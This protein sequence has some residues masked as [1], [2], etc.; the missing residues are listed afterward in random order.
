M[1][2]Y[3]V[4]VI[5]SGIGGLT[6]ALSCARAGRSV[7][8]LEAGKQYGGYSNPF[9]R[10]HFHFDP[11]IHY[12]GECG[13]DG[14]F[15]QLLDKLGLESV[16]FVELDRDAIDHYVF[17]DYDRLPARAREPRAV[18]PLPRRLRYHAQVRARHPLRAGHVACRTRP[19]EHLALEPR[20]GDPMPR[21]LLRGSAAQGCA[22]RAMR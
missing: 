1:T 19:A 15:R 17:P 11:G 9:A 20:D 13:P 14:A 10:K 5:G 7:L 21:S 8:V 6:A 18:L 2:T 22:Q 3:D 16:G 12:I 4:I